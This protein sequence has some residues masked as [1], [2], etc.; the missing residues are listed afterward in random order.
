MRNL[1]LT[2]QYDGTNFNGWQLQPK[3]RT[4]Q[5]EIENALKTIFQTT[6]RVHGSGRTDTGVHALGQVANF[7]VD[8]PKSLDSIKKA[9]NANTKKDVVT[10]KVEDAPEDFH[11]Q[12]SA[13]LKTYRYTIINNDTINP[14]ERYYSL[15]FPHKLNLSAMKRAAKHLV[16][17]KDFK[18]FQG[19]NRVNKDQDT[20]RTI[21]AITLKKEGV[22]ITIDIT[23]TGFLYKMVRNIVGLLIAVG[24][25]QIEDTKT[26]EILKAKNRTKAPATALAHGLTLFNVKY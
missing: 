15:H 9:I 17:K 12:Y 26:K 19:N 7:I 6:I 14:L 25:G 16:G 8:T 13:K 11:A 20:V 4:V 23:A 24:S 2:I 3:D 5:G 18:S 1:K 10:Q 22:K 21:K